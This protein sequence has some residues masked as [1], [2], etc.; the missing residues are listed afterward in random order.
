MFKLWDRVREYILKYGGL[1]G[2]KVQCSSVTCLYCGIGVGEYIVKY[3]GL[4]GLK[5]QCTSVTCSYCGIG[6]RVFFSEKNG[7]H[8]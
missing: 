3:G 5:V 7:F 4:Q 2:L 6:V 8:F 1:H